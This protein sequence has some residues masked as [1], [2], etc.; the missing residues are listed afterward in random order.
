MLSINVQ[1]LKPGC[2]ATFVSTALSEVLSLEHKVMLCPLCPDLGMLLSAFNLPIDHDYTALN[3]E[4]AVR[5]SDQLYLYPQGSKLFANVNKTVGQQ[6]LQ[7]LMDYIKGLGFDIL[8]FDCGCC[9]FRNSKAAFA[10]SDL[11]LTLLQPNMACMLTAA[12][13][14]PADNEIVVFNQNRISSELQTD[15][16]LYASTSFFQEAQAPMTI[17]YDENVLQAAIENTTVTATYDHSAAARA[18]ESLALFCMLKLKDEQ[19]AED[20]E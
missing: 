11:N 13:H 19:N 6:K 12:A 5:I 17:P 8:I 4:Q 18:V 20:K 2:G 16:I 3:Q 7:T 9:D 1:T 14:K 15:L 10:L